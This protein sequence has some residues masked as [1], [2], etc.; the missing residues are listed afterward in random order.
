[1][2]H[3][4]ANETQDPGE[5]DRII[6][7]ELERLLDSPMFT[8][9]PVLSRLLQFLVEHRLRGGIGGSQFPAHAHG[10]G[11]L[12][13]KDICAG[14]SDAPLFLP[15]FGPD[16]RLPGGI[17]QPGHRRNRGARAAARRRT[18]RVRAFRLAS[19][20]RTSS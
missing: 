7:D 13:G 8:R 5:T 12:A 2:D 4:K 16:V 6:A 11:P 10:L 1:M 3:A 9:S 17:A 14:H 18:G 15:G 19:P 20:G